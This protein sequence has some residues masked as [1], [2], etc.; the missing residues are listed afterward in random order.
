[1]NNLYPG[2]K[3]SSGLILLFML[4]F[5][6]VSG[7]APPNDNICN[8]I[9]FDTTQGPITVDNTGATGQAGEPVGS[10]WL[11]G[12]QADN[13]IWYFIVP[14]GTNEYTVTT[15]LNPLG[16]NNDTEIGV[17]TSTGGCSGALTE[18]A[19]GEDDGQVAH[20]YLSTALICNSSFIPGDTLWIQVDTWKID[21]WFLT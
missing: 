9:E 10:C 14:V 15:D 21:H 3:I 19:C 20:I 1:M 6:V 2:I 18:I 5:S 7:Q 17:Y 4:W 11:V 12:Q 16:T 13:S 8:A